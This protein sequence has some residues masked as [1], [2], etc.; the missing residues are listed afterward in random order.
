MTCTS[1][2]QYARTS[3]PPPSPGGSAVTLEE[4]LEILLQPAGEQRVGEVVPP[5]FAPGPGDLLRVRCVGERIQH[6]PVQMGCGI[7]GQ[8]AALGDAVVGEHGS[9]AG[10]VQQ[11]Q[12][13]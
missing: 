4:R 13:C 12:G 9:D 5:Q 2:E 3:L 7:I 8:D 6:P 1:L 11:R 10:T